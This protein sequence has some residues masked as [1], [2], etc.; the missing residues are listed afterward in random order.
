MCFSDWGQEDTVPLSPARITEDNT[1]IVDARTSGLFFKAGAPVTNINKQPPKIT[2]G[3]AS[4]DLHVS[5][6]ECE[7][8]R[9]ELRGKV[10]IKG[11]VMPSFTHNLMG[12]SHF[13]DADCMVQYTKKKVT[14]FNPRGEP[15]VKG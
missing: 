11:H 7:L 6:A 8:N 12:I 3:T 13:C 14:I 10:Y 15:L 4:E 5:S 1:T 9:P 2:V